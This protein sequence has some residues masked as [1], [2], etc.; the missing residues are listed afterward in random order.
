MATQIL[1]SA[2]ASAVPIPLPALP[3]SYPAT[4][5]G[6]ASFL[7][8]FLCSCSSSSSSSSTQSSTT[9]SLVVET[10][11]PL[12]L[13]DQT[14]TSESTLPPIEI[15]TFV[16]YLHSHDAITQLPPLLNMIEKDHIKTGFQDAIAHYLLCDARGHL[17]PAS[18][19]FGPIVSDPSKEIDNVRAVDDRF[20][21]SMLPPGVSIGIKMTPDANPVASPLEYQ[22]KSDPMFT[23]LKPM[24]DVVDRLAPIVTNTTPLPIVSIQNLHIVAKPVPPPAN[25]TPANQTPAN[26][27]TL[28]K[29]CL[30]L[31]YFLNLRNIPNLPLEYTRQLLPHE[32][33]AAL[34][35]VFGREL[36]GASHVRRQLGK[37]LLDFTVFSQSSIRGILLWGPPGTGKTTI[38][39][40]MWKAL[41]IE[42]LVRELAS[43]NF[44]KPLQGV[45]E[46]IVNMI[47]T[48]ASLIPWLLA[49]F[50]VDEIDALAPD[51]NSA[52]SSSVDLLS[53]LLSVVGGNQDAPNVIILGSTN[54]RAAMDAA[55][56]RRLPLQLFVGFLSPAGRQEWLNRFPTILN[57]QLNLSPQAFAM[58]RQA[59]V[60]FAPDKM[61]MLMGD[62]WAHLLPN[63]SAIITTDVALHIAAK[64]AHDKA[65][66]IG[67]IN[68]PALLADPTGPAS[69]MAAPWFAHARS[70]LSSPT[71]TGASRYLIDLTL[72]AGENAIQMQP[73]P[74]RL[75]LPSLALLSARVPSTPAQKSAYTQKVL[76]ALVAELARDENDASLIFYG[77]NSDRAQDAFSR[78][79]SGPTQDSVS[80]LSRALCSFASQPVEA[81]GPAQTPL[82]KAG[83][84]L[85]YT[86]V[87]DDRNV[88]FLHVLDG[89]D[90]VANRLVTP[91]SILSH[92]RTIIETGNEYERSII[93]VDLDSLVEAY[94]TPTGVAE[95]SVG[96]PE[97]TDSMVRVDL[98]RREVFAGIVRLFTSPLPPVV[99]T[100]QGV[101]TFHWLVALSESPDILRRFK[102]ETNWESPGDAEKLEQRERAQL[103]YRC[104]NCLSVFTEFENEDDVC[105][106]HIGHVRLMKQVHQGDPDHDT[107]TH[108]RGNTMGNRGKQRQG[109][110]TYRVIPNTA[111]YTY[112]EAISVL[113][114]ALAPTSG[115]ENITGIVPLDL[116]NHLIW[117]C[118]HR[119][120]LED[121]KM[122]R[123]HV[124][125]TRAEMDMYR[126][127]MGL[128]SDD[129]DV[130]GVDDADD[131]ADANVTA[132]G[133]DVDG[134]SSSSSSSR[135]L[136][137]SRVENMR[138]YEVH[139]AHEV[140]C[141]ARMENREDDAAT[142]ETY[143]AMLQQLDAPTLIELREAL[144]NPQRP[145]RPVQVL[146]QLPPAVVDSAARGT[147][148]PGVASMLE[149]ESW[150][151][152]RV[153]NRDRVVIIIRTNGRSR[154]HDLWAVR[155]P[156]D[157]EEEEMV[158]GMRVIRVAAA[159]EEG[160]TPLYAV[161]VDRDQE[162]DG[163]AAVAHDM[164]AK[165]PGI[166]PVMAI[167]YE[168]R[169]VDNNMVSSLNDAVARVPT[170][171]MMCID[172]GALSTN[173]LR[174]MFADA[175]HWAGLQT[176]TLFT[177][178]DLVTR[179]RGGGSARRHR[180]AQAHV[181]TLLGVVGGG[182]GIRVGGWVAR[183]VDELVCEC[184]DE[185]SRVRGTAAAAAAM[186][187]ATAVATATAAATAAATAFALIE[188]LHNSAR[189][190]VLASMGIP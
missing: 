185:R 58:L 162:T 126:G 29:L 10:E 26:P 16:L 85:L 117:D 46:M 172:S 18:S 37:Q 103:S 22:R 178:Q 90:L 136:D 100:D 173:G 176:H 38:I 104:K 125:M 73:T 65:I 159:T 120:L 70:L 67:G 57:R 35:T 148:D 98:L 3:P 81:F 189:V 8:S 112:L 24:A 137:H 171:R 149:V 77:P 55:F 92:I 62:L 147:V 34:H 110:K 180:M 150:I 105:P 72:P 89:E 59:T 139:R 156:A 28:R 68:I 102:R 166:I 75:T 33:N 4:K 188:T 111:S 7:E 133:G 187:T 12:N 64:L 96:Y 54:L 177:P 97:T 45:S 106:C 39:D 25:Q 152:A 135:V 87:V 93:I 115:S 132:G 129:E 43:G 23:S 179:L 183:R 2:N 1:A 40:R 119:P 51:R 79:L 182:G 14:P 131:Q 158:P 160:E 15:H 20:V 30:M 91:E 41:G 31:G 116:P 99:D 157:G 168:D 63:P 101:E 60:G 11:D 47:K 113:R 186:A 76:C 52:E 109:Q 122:K 145:T 94:T 128:D 82:T 164:L 175:P 9:T 161:L 151:D 69:L 140:A 108:P 66:R 74:H 36:I 50:T 19:L 95:D 27:R 142:A 107:D 118:C 114:N 121:G 44:K 146:S 5:N 56:L 42:L 13:P 144:H 84:L 169:D 184:H 134:A 141:V 21:C 143:A 17:G 170:L 71:A 165:I 48:R 49:A 80:A 124:P 86:Q 61:I 78:V 88:D 174:D 123:R 138:D 130:V 153:N 32:I 155:S 190:T 53:V 167:Q 127:W 154:G 163:W 83:A 181:R 6:L